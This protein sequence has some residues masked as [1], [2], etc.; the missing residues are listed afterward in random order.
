MKKTFKIIIGI[1]LG[2]VT[3]SIEWVFF[4]ILSDNYA[5]YL[6]TTDIKYA[7]YETV[8]YMF[9][10]CIIVSFVTSLILTTF[11]V[12][13]FFKLRKAFII[14]NI[15][16]LTL[17]I[18]AVIYILSTDNFIPLIRETIELIDGLK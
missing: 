2:L 13:C 8:I 6:S 10:I 11:Y 9:K 16:Y 18:M 12:I 3:F 1:I 7:A 15:I 4:Y 14:F 5:F 17:Q